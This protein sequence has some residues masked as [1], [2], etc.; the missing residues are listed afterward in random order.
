MGYRAEEWFSR[1]SLQGFQGDGSGLKRIWASG[2]ES[3]TVLQ[4][5]VRGGAGCSDK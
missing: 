3:G 2:L 1:G 4:R 5:W